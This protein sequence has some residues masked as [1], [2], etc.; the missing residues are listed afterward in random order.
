VQ[1]GAR[2]CALL[3]GV[4]FCAASAAIAQTDL[5]RAVNVTVA[6]STTATVRLLKL[7]KGTRLAFVIEGEQP[8]SVLILDEDN[9]NRFPQP[10]A[11]ALISGRAGPALS[12][13]VQLPADGNFYLVLD[14]REH[15]APNKVRM[16]LRATLPAGT[17][18][19]AEPKPQV[20]QY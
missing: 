18:K 10:G 9:F 8:L 13:G 5:T 2:G 20:Q 12:F 3:L 14:N 7:S 17:R 16:Q 19:P 11:S 15:A 6:E 4:W 1:P